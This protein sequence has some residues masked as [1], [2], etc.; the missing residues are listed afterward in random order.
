MKWD[1]NVD[2]FCPHHRDLPDKDPLGTTDPFVTVYL[3]ENDE[4]NEKEI[5]RSATLTDDEN[6]DWSDVFSFDFDRKKNQVRKLARLTCF[7]VLHL[8]NQNC[9]LLLQRLHFIIRDHDFGQPDDHVAQVWVSVNEYVDKKQYLQVNL[10]KRG[11]L[12]VK[13]V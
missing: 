12:I 10:I 7:C 3:T 9:L 1:K 13:K 5:G 6:P 8:Q 2:N 4:K 11:Y